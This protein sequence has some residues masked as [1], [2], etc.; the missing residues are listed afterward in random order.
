MMKIGKIIMINPLIGS[1]QLQITSYL[2]SSVLMPG[3]LTIRT[4]KVS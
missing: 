3:G 4:N 1:F 2:K